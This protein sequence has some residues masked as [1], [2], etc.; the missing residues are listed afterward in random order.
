M[1]IRSAIP[2][3]VSISKFIAL[4]RPHFLAGGFLLY[5][6][7]AFAAGVDSI[8]A[9]LIGQLAITASQL[10]AHFVNEFADA[11]ADA[12]VVNR[13]WF[14]GGSGVLVDPDADRAIAL[15]AAYVSSAVS[16]AAS[17]VLALD[18]PLAASIAAATLLISWGYSMPPVRLLD[19]GWGEAATTVVTTVGVPLVGALAQAGPID[20]N[21][22]WVI[23]VLFALHMAMIVAFE[24]P[25]LETDTTAAKTV[26]AV[27]L[28]LPNTRRIIAVFYA[29]GF[30]TVLAAALIVET[31]LSWM[32]LGIPFAVVTIIASSTDR[33]GVLT[34][35]AVAGVGAAAIG[36]LVILI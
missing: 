25:D 17:A 20:H 35:A 33:F 36:G 5:A 3:T 15:R 26:L 21:L 27:R 19:T 23:T 22:W 12:L 18:H 24:I 4:A 11:E 29:L 9:Y 32:L 16:L 10:T 31:D 2:C 7:G 28:G 30:G 1:L 34:T 13:T 14:S 8:S 6:I